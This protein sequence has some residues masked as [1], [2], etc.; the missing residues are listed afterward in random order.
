MKNAKKRPELKF[1]QMDAT[2][3]TYEDCSFS[4]VLDRGNL[5]ARMKEKKEESEVLVDKMFG[6]I[7]RVLKVGGRYIC[8]TIALENL[9]SKLLSYFSSEGWMV[10][11]HKIDSPNKDDRS[12]SR[13]PLPI[14][15][16]VS[17]KFKKMAALQSPILELSLSEG[18]SPERVSSIEDI[19]KA[20]RS[21]QDYAMLQHNLNKRS[22]CN[23]SVSLD[24]YAPN[25]KNPRFTLYIVD[26]PK[27]KIPANKF[28]IF[29]VPQ[30]RETEYLFGTDKGR[31]QLANQAGFQRLVVATLHRGH[32]YQSV[33]S[34]KS[35][36]SSRVMEL[37]PSDLP[38]N[39][40]VPFL[41]IGEDVGDREVMYEGDSSYGNKVIVEDVRGED[42]GKYR[43][44]VF[45]SNQSNVQSQARLV[46]EKSRSKSGKKR[47]KEVTRVDHLYLPMDFHRAMTAGL[48]LLPGCLDV[49]RTKARVLII[50]LGG[51][52]LPMF[53]YKQ[54][55]KFE[56]DVVELDPMLKDIAK[57]WFG[58]IE[59]ERLR[60]HIQDGLEFI[61]SSAEKDPP[62]LYNV[63]M[64]DVDSKDFSEGLTAPPKAF[65][66]TVVLEA[67]KTILHPTQGIF[68]LNFAC[69]DDL[70]KESVISDIQKHFPTLYASQLE[71][72][73]NEIVLCLPHRAS[74]GADKRKVQYRDDARAL[75]KYAK[76][77]TSRWESDFD[78]CEIIDDLQ[79]K[80]E[81]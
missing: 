17:T 77:V 10:R 49:I 50:G 9:I 39:T 29:I 21:Q 78:L 7:G 73:I 2:Q 61:K 33:D 43:Q 58:L 56:I 79:I 13:S 27:G 46:T 3:M 37:G 66:E 60:I 26:K 15:I 5:D 38:S 8:I 42:G 28:A 30:G 74:E 20:I 64:F 23:E 70:L 11:V 25:N 32:T 67:V 68:I 22:F 57:S 18:S 16:V 4:V 53:L 35:E 69:R 45:S 59:D 1:E 19:I 48:T 54:F 71:D 65:L 44:I 80:D 40:Q 6:E 52:G 12:E 55:P 51:G 62:N 36:L 14:F 47:G 41:S 81:R 72:D 24:L 63:V 76:S 75:Q 31:G 34:I